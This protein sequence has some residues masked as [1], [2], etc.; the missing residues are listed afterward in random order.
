MTLRPD[1]SGE[2]QWGGGGEQPSRRCLCS[3]S[4][5]LPVFA[6]CMRSSSPVRACCQVSECMY[7]SVLMMRISRSSSGM[8]APVRQPCR[9]M[10]S[11]GKRM[12]GRPRHQLGGLQGPL[13][14]LGKSP[15]P[16]P[17]GHCK[18][19]HRS[20]AHG[21]LAILS[22]EE[23]QT[24]FPGEQRTLLSQRC[25]RMAVGARPCPLP[26][27]PTLQRQLKPAGCW[28][29]LSRGLPAPWPLTAP[30]S[31]RKGVG[32]CLPKRLL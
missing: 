26:V 27:L 28:A 24:G 16:S 22:D 25:S 31:N 1:K 4:H 6:T 20:R 5:Q 32:F 7:C 21:A 17:P 18:G 12:E 23:N 3:S 2:T 8:M 13:P 15:T 14:S 10:R 11:W 30:P 9:T 29:A 19:G